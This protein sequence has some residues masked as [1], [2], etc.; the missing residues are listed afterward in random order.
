MCDV[1]LRNLPRELQ[2]ILAHRLAHPRREFVYGYDRFP[3]P[4]RHLLEAFTVVYRNDA[5]AAASFRQRHV[6]NFI[7]K[8]AD[9]RCKN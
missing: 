1:L 8:R 9:R 2:T 3:E 5:S 6:R 7:N 4:C